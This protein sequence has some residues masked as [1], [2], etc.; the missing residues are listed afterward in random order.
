MVVTAGVAFLSAVVVVV[1]VVEVEEECIASVDGFLSTGAAA[2]AA[3]AA[4]VAFLAIIS[5]V[6]DLV[7][8]KTVIATHTQSKPARPLMNTSRPASAPP[9]PVF[10]AVLRLL[11]FLVFSPFVPFMP[12]S[13]HMDRDQVEFGPDNTTNVVRT[14]ISGRQGITCSACLRQNH[15]MRF[16]H[17]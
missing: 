5:V 3:A 17:L 15:L 7:I 11:R 14:G 13:L 8:S 6:L 10:F 2:A 16:A 4:R 12:V 9:R 1:V